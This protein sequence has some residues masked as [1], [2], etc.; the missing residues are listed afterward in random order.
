MQRTLLLLTL[1]AAM[2]LTLVPVAAQDDAPV[3]E[4]LDPPET[5]TVAYVP[6]MKFAA[7]YVAEERGI[8]DKYGLD[9]E[10]ERVSSGTEAI[11]FLTE[12]QIDIGGIAIV[13]SLWNGWNDGLDIRIIAPGALEPFEDSPT[14]LIAR[15]DLV[16]SGEVETVADLAGRT[17]S[18][19]GGP[20]SGGEYLLSKALEGGGLTIFDAN[21]VN[22]ANPDMPAA[23]ENGTVDAAMVG[24][25]FADQII[26]AGNGVAIAEDF[27]PGLMTVAFVGS[28]NFVTERPEVAERFAIALM[29]ATRIMQGEDY[30]ADE[31]LEAYLTYTNSTEEA[32]RS[33]NPVIY[34]PNQVIPVDGLAD[35]ERVH[36]E[37]GRT[38]YEDPIDLT[39][40]VMTEFTD[41]AREL[42][43]EVETDFGMMMDDEMMEE[44]LEA[45]E[46]AS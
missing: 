17:V 35:V 19:A 29:E 22:I 34:D 7:M 37:N 1:L 33:G 2:A 9:V 11:A 43:G 23:I 3:V 26:E 28:G 30:L 18:L 40:V 25:P 42:L 10:I 36:R 21:I 32:L 15:A 24:S 38:E 20:G 45:T 4:P 5:V 8:F 44:D 13:T 31:N 16:E 6:I 27:V 39:N 14:K 46:E 41:T 12:G